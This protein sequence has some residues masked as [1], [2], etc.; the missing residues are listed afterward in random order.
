MSSG[1]RF[2]RERKPEAPAG[3]QAERT[4]RRTA[5]TATRA[6]NKSIT[7][8][9]D[10]GTLDAVPEEKL[11]TPPALG[12][13][14]VKVQVPKVGSKPFPLIVPLPVMPR[15][16]ASWKTTVEELKSNV[17]PPTLQSAGVGV[18]GLKIHGVAMA[19]ESPT[20]TD[21]AKSS[22]RLITVTL[23]KEFTRV[24]DARDEVSKTA[25][26]ANVIA[27]SI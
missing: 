7:V 15:K 13:C 25:P 27:P 24:A 11:N 21:E 5:S 17:K 1:L 19:T 22:E 2:L 8:V 26:P 3:D 6:P 14:E 16:L 12:D 20:E 4:F 9:P 10:S 23:L 18:D